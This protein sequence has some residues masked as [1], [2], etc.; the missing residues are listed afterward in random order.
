MEVEVKGRL[1]CQMV[2]LSNKIPVGMWKDLWL[3]SHYIFIHF[4]AEYQHTE[5]YELCSVECYFG[6]TLHT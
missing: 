4:T 6:P 1:A 5:S 3:L 2:V